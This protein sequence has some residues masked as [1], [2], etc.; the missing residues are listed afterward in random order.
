MND[1][2]PK[3]RGFAAMDPEKRKAICAKAGRL[4]HERGKAHQFSAEEAAAAGRKGGANLAK[5]RE[6][7]AAIGRKGG[8]AKAAKRKVG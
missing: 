6:H 7:M 8:K 5:D 3:P 4:A 1:E 2:K